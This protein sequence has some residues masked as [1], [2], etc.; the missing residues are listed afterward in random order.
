LTLPASLR[1]FKCQGTSW[2][3][4]AE[5]FCCKSSSSRPAYPQ[6][7]PIGPQG[8]HRMAHPM[9]SPWLTPRSFSST[10]DRAPAPCPCVTSHW[11]F[12]KNDTTLLKT[13]AYRFYAGIH[14]D[15]SASVMEYVGYARSDR[16]AGRYV[17]S[18][19]RS[20][21]VSCDRWLIQRSGP[22]SPLSSRHCVLS[23]ECVILA[24]SA[25]STLRKQREGWTARDCGES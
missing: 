6:Q 4:Q 8:T 14:P 7:C 12:Q 19:D 5:T 18:Q 25:L 16:M 15:M 3:P 1:P 24:R 20:A 11:C 17:V 2:E 21:P 10:G 23:T 13:T 9:R 22:T